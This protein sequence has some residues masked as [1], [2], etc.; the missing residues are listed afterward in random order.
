MSTVPVEIKHRRYCRVFYFQS[1][2][3]R[4]G[5]LPAFYDVAHSPLEAS[6]LAEQGGVDIT[7]DKRELRQY[8]QWRRTFDAESA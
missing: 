3:S 1:E 6:F 2:Q 4:L 7:H 5:Q 8:E